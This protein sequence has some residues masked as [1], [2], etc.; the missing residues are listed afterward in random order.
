MYFDTFSEFLAMGRHGL[1]V[2]L[3]YGVFL[4]VILWN[5]WL[6]AVTRRESIKLA[7]RTWQREDAKSNTSK[8]NVSKSESPSASS[9]GEL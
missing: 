9:K 5:I 4:A 1:Y 3:S 2:W 8:S 6:V 7:Q